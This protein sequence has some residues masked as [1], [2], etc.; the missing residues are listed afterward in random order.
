MNLAIEGTPGIT[1]YYVTLIT[2]PPANNMTPA[3]VETGSAPPVFYTNQLA[4]SQSVT[5]LPSLQTSNGLVTVEAV[6]VDGQNS[7]SSVTSASFL[8]EVAPIQLNGTNAAQFTLFDVTTN[9]TYVYTTDGSDPLTSSNAQQLITS[10]NTTPFSINIGTNFVFTVVG[11]DPGFATSQPLKYT[12]LGQNFHATTLSWGFASGYCSSEFI[13]SPGEIFFAPVTLSTLPG[14]AMFGLDFSMI[15][16]NLGSDMVPSGDFGFTSMLM[17]LVNTPSGPAF[18]QIPPL[19][20][21]GN[22][23]NP[24]PPSQLL[25]LPYNGSTN[26]VNLTVPNTNLNRL[27]VGWFETFGNTNLFNTKSQNLLTYSLAFVQ[28]IPS[29]PSFPNQDIVGSYFFQVPTNATPG[30]QYQIQ[31][32]RA[33]GNGDGLDGPNS[34]VPVILPLS[35]SLTN[36]AINAIKVVTVGQPKYLAGDIYPFHWLNAGDFGSGDLTNHSANDIIGTFNAAVYDINGPPPGSDFYDAMDSAGGIG[37]FNA[38]AGY[39]TKTGTLSGA[40]LNALFN[41]ND[42]TTINTMAFGDGN[43]DICDVFATFAR[44]QFPNMYWFERYYTNDPVHGVFGRIAQAVF[45]QTNVFINNNGILSHPIKSADGSDGSVT[46][47]AIS[48]TNTP[49]V[50]FSAGD[51]LASA[52]QTVSIPITMTVFGPYAS[53][54][55]MLNVAV[56]PL[57]G[58]PALTAAPTFTLNAPFS[59]SSLYNPPGALGVQDNSHG[60]YA[61][62]F[63][64]T[65][66]PISTNADVMGSNIIGYLN[67][68][69]PAN[70]TSSSAYALHFNHASASPN[71]LVSFP[72]TIYT[73]LITLSSRTNSNYGD[74]IIPD[75][76]RLRY[77]GTIYN[78]LSVASADAD[79]TG[80]NNYQKYLAGLDPQDPTSVLN[81]GTDQPMAQS[82]QDHVVYW[83]TVNGKTYTIERSAT[84]FPG[85]WTSISTNAG[86]GTYMEIHDAPAGANYFYRVSTK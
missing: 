45:P 13:A 67:V 44:S 74:G 51:Y 41:V 53:R 10:S 20:F 78:Q 38:A 71:G 76:W 6:N 9:L 68:T 85:Q 11:E 12:F 49:V 35:G 4:S 1:T 19:M 15:V 22:A 50:H 23:V 82:S 69:I 37:T 83:P 75:S 42:A 46:S 62:A 72:K 52:G 25:Q 86:T 40:A 24:P 29:T 3:Y 36:G 61:A 39:W 59:N 63:L 33:S 60:N 56:V 73:G 65:S 81:E 30:E 80:V 54:M 27:A 57:D 5:P 31:L 18:E 34:D 7:P 32:D 64:P 66:L 26:F 14:T 28:L 2:N 43:I 21:A 17:E 70:A 58:S 48:I 55:M 77:F 16:T 84:L 47:Q 79:G 8:F